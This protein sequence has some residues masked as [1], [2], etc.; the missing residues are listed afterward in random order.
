MVFVRG[1]L[2]PVLDSRERLGL[3]EQD[4]ADDPHIICVR[5]HGRLVGLTVDEAL[6]LITL[7]Y[8][9]LVGAEALGAQAGFFVGLVE[10]NG[11]I[12]RLLDPDKLLGHDE[13]RRLESVHQS[14]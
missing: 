8:G 3:P 6:D 13:A 14:S 2:I 9:A 10:Q 7:D 1:H 12:I 11:Q 5:A 4:R